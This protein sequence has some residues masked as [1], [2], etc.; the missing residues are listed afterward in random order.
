MSSAI[1]ESFVAP[2]CV[3]KVRRYIRVRAPHA[4]EQLQ[5]NKK[6]TY[7]YTHVHTDAHIW[8]SIFVSRF[9][10]SVVDLRVRSLRV[11]RLVAV[12]PNPFGQVPLALLASLLVVNRF[13]PSQRITVVVCIVK[14]VS[15]LR[16][17]LISMLRDGIHPHT[18]SRIAISLPGSLDART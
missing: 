9:N 7:T 13:S 12:R 16:E 15:Y 4:R 6:C 3:H 10:R 1:V 2:E 11:R 14:L 5:F 17:H 18:E 8:Y